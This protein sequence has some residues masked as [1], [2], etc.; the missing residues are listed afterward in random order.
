MSR[1]GQALSDR[2]SNS[3][4]SGAEIV[5]RKAAPDDAKTIAALTDAAYAKYVP[6]L[7]RKP[8]TMMADYDKIIAE[9]AVW[10]LCL[11]D[12][13]VGALVLMEEP[14]AMLIFSVLIAPEHQGRG[15]GRQLLSLAEDQARRAGY[16]LIRLYT[17]EHMVE[18]IE[19]YRRLGYEETA[20]E[21]YL[22]SA[23]V[24]MAKRLET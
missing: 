19:L 8:S 10:L 17:N 22:G 7:R 21:H 23:V 6:R 15:L 4:E 12:Q 3:D 14:D 5:I 16:A 1:G 2:G 11:G 18:N 20:R 9:H 24:H 13:P